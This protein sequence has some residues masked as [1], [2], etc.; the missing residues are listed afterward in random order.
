VS[1]GTAEA[2]GEVDGALVDPTSQRITHLYV[3]HG[4]SDTFVGWDEV[5][6]VGPDAVMLG[7]DAAPH[8]PENDRE[9]AAASGKLTILGKR[10][11]DDLGFAHGDLTDLEFDAETGAV[12]GLT[13]EDVTLPPEALLG[14]GAYAVVIRAPA[15][16]SAG[17]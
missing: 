1:G 7:A 5:D 15:E 3:R 6:A 8:E 9:K 17:A 2:Q 4:R 10:V 11:L 14:I 16:V 12:T 13:I